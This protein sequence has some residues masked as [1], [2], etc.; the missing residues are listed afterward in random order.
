MHCGDDASGLHFLFARYT[1]HTSIH[2]HPFFTLFSSLHFLKQQ[3]EL[4]LKEHRW[5]I[6]VCVFSN[7]KTNFRKNDD[8]LFFLLR[9]CAALHVHTICTEKR[10]KHFLYCIHAWPWRT[11]ALK[12]RDTGRHARPWRTASEGKK[13][14]GKQAFF[15]FCG[16]TTYSLL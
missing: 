2:P 4:L 9:T 6:Y 5:S 10:N 16:W 11:Q 1:L 8:I 12:R 14:S 3:N 7:N 15:F 13:R